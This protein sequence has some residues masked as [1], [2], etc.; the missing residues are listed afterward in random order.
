M[1]WDKQADVSR[2]RVSKALISQGKESATERIPPRE[3][4]ATPIPQGKGEKV[5]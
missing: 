1:W 2:C 3:M 4:A 5:R